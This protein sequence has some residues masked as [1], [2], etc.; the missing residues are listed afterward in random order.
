M[1]V[2]D[3][4]CERKSDLTTSAGATTFRLRA[5]GLTIFLDTWLERPDV[6]PTYLKIEEV[7]HADYIF[8]SHAH[9]DH[10]P[11]C[12]RLAKKTGA[13]VVAN[14][15]AINALRKA[16]VP[17][18]QLLPVAGGERIPLFLRTVREAARVGKVATAPGP[19]GA[20]LQP[21]TDLA[22]VSVHAWPSLHC[23]LPGSSHADIP[24]VMDT[25]T[26]YDGS[27]QYAC[28]IDITRGMQYGLLRLGQIVPP[29]QLDAGERSFIE[30]VSDR[31]SNIMSNFDGGQIS[32]SFLIGEKTLMWNGHLGGYRGILQ[33]LEPKPGMSS[34]R[35]TGQ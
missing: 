33:N 14:G 11:G 3:H 6:L 7:E 17:E 15:E 10:L 29:D 12:D 18:E 25:G 2:L 31:K 5:K 13:V 1:C 34:F 8:V 16:G 26:S 19:P 22:V 4:L 30:Y 32:F 24:D 9:F 28:T 20:P 27:S 21:H 23:L 35:V